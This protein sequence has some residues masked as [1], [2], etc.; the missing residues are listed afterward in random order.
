MERLTPQA[1]VIEGMFCIIDKQ[2]NEVDF[3]LNPSQ[4]LYDLKR[5]HRDL[6][7]KARQKGFSSLGIAYQTVDCL[8][9]YGTR[10]V[11]ISH[12]ARSTQRLLDKARYYLEHVKGPKPELGRHSRN[13]FFFPKTESTYYI[14]TAGA[15]AF[16]RG[17]TITHLHISEYAW[18]ESDA[19]EKVAGLFQAVPLG[20]TIRIESTGNGRNNDFYYMCMNANDLGYGV[21][22]RSWWEDPEYSLQASGPWEPRGFEHYF[23]DMQSAFGLTDDQLYWY[24]VKLLEFRLDLKFMQQEYPSTLEEC[25]QATGGAVFPN[26]HRVVIPK[27]EWR[28]DQE[29]GIRYER[30]SDHPQPNK[31]YILGGDPSGGTGNDNASLEVFSLEDLEQVAEFFNNG[32]DPVGFAYLMMRFGFF[33]NTAFLVPEANKH[34]A[35]VV[36]VLRKEYPTTR[37]YKRHI[38]RSGEIKYG[39]MTTENTKNAMVGSIIECLDM[40]LI[41]HSLQLEKELRGFEEDPDHPGKYEGHPDDCVIALG[42]ACIGIFKY[43]HRRIQ[44]EIVVEHP[45]YNETYEGV[46]LMYYTYDEIFSKRDR[47]RRGFQP[48]PD[49]Q[50]MLHRGGWGNA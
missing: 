24:W 2:G 36:P 5:T 41:I 6:I 46:N 9:K 43:Y 50:S 19:L 12:E 47:P 1:Q 29:T 3:R 42:L 39:F 31:T 35:A 32:I 13:E 48:L 37:L 7:P 14:G 4:R 23:Q 11:L 40:G 27:W 10:S 17:D 38:P 44:R 8:T 22:F 26:I 30:H 33:Y 25:F 21:H 16:G 49:R 18:W 20:G 34:G 15:K 28:R 45:A